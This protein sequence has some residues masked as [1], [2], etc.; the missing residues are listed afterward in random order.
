MEN[1]SDRNK[2]TKK[3]YEKIEL[4]NLFDVILEK[5]FKLYKNLIN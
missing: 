4:T 5:E 1:T 2:I 3:A